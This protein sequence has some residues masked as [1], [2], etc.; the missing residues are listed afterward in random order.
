MMDNTEQ[1]KTN[2]PSA[3][4]NVKNP[5]YPSGSVDHSKKNTNPVYT[6]LDT[7]LTKYDL[8]QPKIKSKSIR[9]KYPQYGRLFRAMNCYPV[10]AELVDEEENRQSIFADCEIPKSDD[11]NESV[12]AKGDVNLDTSKRTRITPSV[13]FEGDDIEENRQSIFEVCELPQQFVTSS[14]Q[15]CSQSDSSEKCTVDEFR[16]SEIPCSSEPQNFSRYR[17]LFPPLRRSIS[18]AHLLHPQNR[19]IRVSNYLQTFARFLR[20]NMG[21]R[22]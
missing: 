13:V 22:K 14:A 15:S 19:W 7:V 2:T 1:D 4:N 8:E 16:S 5:F 10:S 21:C 20:P 18:E 3:S 12:S 17:L 9:A 6:N 11:K